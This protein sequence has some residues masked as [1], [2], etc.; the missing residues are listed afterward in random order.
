MIELSDIN[1]RPYNNVWVV[2]R[3][4]SVRFSTLGA[5]INAMTALAI[6]L[7]LDYIDASLAG[8]CI[9]F[10]LNFTDQVCKR[11]VSVVCYFTYA[12]KLMSSL[13]KDVLGCKTIYFSGTQLQCR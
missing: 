12:V 4:V 6:I 11:Q 9:S 3:W 10:T 1:S 8:M 7:N 5:L 2:N 13:L